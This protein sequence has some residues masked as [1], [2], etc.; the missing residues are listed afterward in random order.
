MGKKPIPLEIKQAKGTV[1]VTRDINKKLP[2]TFDSKKLTDLPEIPTTLDEAGSL[3]YINICKWLLSLNM[4][5]ECDLL[6]VELLAQE[7]CIYYT[8]IENIRGKK[9]IAKSPNDYPIINPYIGIKNKA[10]QNINNYL[11]EL[12]MTPAARTKLSNIQVD[13]AKKMENPI[14]KLMKEKPN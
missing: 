5:Y 6:V 7:M 9:L 3:Y 1:H 8:C 12:G 14:L 11:G 4:L 13:T 2:I 10:L